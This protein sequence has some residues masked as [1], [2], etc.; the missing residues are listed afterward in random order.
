MYSSERL[1]N[2]G[3]NFT[4]Y[5]AKIEGLLNSF[6]LTN[7]DY[8]LF[9]SYSDD[10]VPYQMLYALPG[11]IDGANSNTAFRT[12]KLGMY[13][14]NR[15]L[16]LNLNYNFFDDFFRLFPVPGIKNWNLQ[17]NSFFNAGWIDISDKSKE[18]LPTPTEL[19]VKPLMEAGFGIGYSLLPIKLEFAWRLTHTNENAFSIGI[20][21]A[22]F[23]K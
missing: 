5:K 13:F 7:L 12:A 1:I 14:G 6:W 11:N 16:T 9:A 19:L 21:S 10:A 3:I 4:I 22:I 15:I 2:S 8:K 23:L 17:I 20:N 18:I